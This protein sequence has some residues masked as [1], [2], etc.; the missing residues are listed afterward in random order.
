MDESALILALK[1]G[2]IRAAALD[3]YS[4]DPTNPLL[5]NGLSFRSPFIIFYFRAKLKDA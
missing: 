1:E 2:R 4:P 3:V 5:P